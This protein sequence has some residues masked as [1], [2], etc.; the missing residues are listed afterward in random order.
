MAPPKIRFVTTICHPNI[1]FKTGEI[2]LDLL[3]DNWS[4]AYTI[5]QTLAALHHLLADPVPD[6]PLNVDVAALLR[7]GDRVG[8]ES[9]VRYYTHEYRW[10]G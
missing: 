8:F 10:V 1:H 4:P 9:L 5:A 3:K 2:C 6:S 7:D